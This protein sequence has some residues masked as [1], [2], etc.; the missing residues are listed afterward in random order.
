MHH[1]MTANLAWL[2]HNGR[3]GAPLYEQSFLAASSQQP[4]EEGQKESQH[5]GQA[6]VLYRPWKTSRLEGSEY[7]LCFHTESAF[8]SREQAPTETP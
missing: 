6:L 5:S 7:L 4:T 1:C 8:N 3:S 2:V